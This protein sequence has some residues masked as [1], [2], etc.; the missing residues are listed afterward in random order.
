MKLPEKLFLKDIHRPIE[1]VVKADD[2]LNFAQ[3]VD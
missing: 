1:T 3:E 2:Q